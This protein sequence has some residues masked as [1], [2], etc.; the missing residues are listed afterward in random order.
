MDAGDPQYKGYPFYAALPLPPTAR[1]GKTD[2]FEKF[3][4]RKKSFRY[5]VKTATNDDHFNETMV[6]PSIFGSL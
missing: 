6:E 4:H 1:P 2:F 5:R 3:S